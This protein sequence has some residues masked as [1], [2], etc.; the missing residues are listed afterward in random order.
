MGAVQL[1]MFGP[2]AFELPAR[3]ILTLVY[4][5]LGA[6]MGASEFFDTSMLKANS[7]F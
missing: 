7:L 4:V 3:G 5:A 2:V 1:R 6:Q